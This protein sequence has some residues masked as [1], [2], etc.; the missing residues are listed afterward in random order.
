[1]LAEA[2]SM[3]DLRD[4]RDLAVAAAAYAR[5]HRMGAEAQRYAVEIAAVASRRMAAL[6]PPQAGGRGKKGTAGAVSI[7][8]QRRSENRD[9]LAFT[10]AEV[11]EKVRTLKEP[12]LT[13]IRRLARDKKA[14]NRPATE[15][16]G[17]SVGHSTV[18]RRRLRH[19]SAAVGLRGVLHCTPTAQDARRERVGSGMKDPATDTARSA[20]PATCR[21]AGTTSCPTGRSHS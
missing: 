5:A 15:L 9:L 2:R 13:R 6:D 19:E 21:Q 14:A 3:E 12:T 7:P 8:Q 18:S 20:G 11:V 4:V 10:E 1:M 16:L 17:A